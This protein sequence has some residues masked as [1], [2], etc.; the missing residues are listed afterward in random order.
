MVEAKIRSITAHLV[1]V[2]YF[3]RSVLHFE[4]NFS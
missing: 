3:T 1:R 2:M 4:K